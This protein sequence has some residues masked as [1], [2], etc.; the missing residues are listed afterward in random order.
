MG[1]GLETPRQSPPGLENW[2]LGQGGQ[3]PYSQSIAGCS[4]FTGLRRCSLHVY[5]PDVEHTSCLRRGADSSSRSAATPSPLILVLPRR[6][7]G[8]SGGR[9]RGSG[10][11]V[12]GR[13]GK[14]S[15]LPGGG[16]AHHWGGGGRDRRCTRKNVEAGIQVL[17]GGGEPLP[18]KV[19]VSRAPPSGPLGNRS[20]TESGS[21]GMGGG[22]QFGESLGAGMG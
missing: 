16:T 22:V 2:G 8:G 21:V 6:T 7:W 3:S 9:Q 19:S 13:G 18:L 5:K 20:S 10:G 11:R 4:V 14:G 17:P 12:K 15:L 1:V